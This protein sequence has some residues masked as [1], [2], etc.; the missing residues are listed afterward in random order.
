MD[1]DCIVHLIDEPWILFLPP[2]K[3]SSTH[4]KSQAVN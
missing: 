3:A 2:I 4:Y 1:N